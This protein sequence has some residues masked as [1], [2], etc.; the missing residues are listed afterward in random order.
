MARY[1]SDLEDIYF[2]LFNILKV[3]EKNK[4]FGVEEIKSVVMEFDKFVAHEIFSTREEGDQV[5]VK[6][7]GGKVV[8]P[9][10]YIRAKNNYHSNGWFALGM[11][12]EW[13]GMPAPHAVYLACQSLFIGSN[14][15]F[16]MYPGLSK[17][18]LNAIKELGTQEQKERFIPKMMEGAWGGTMCLTEPGAGSDV[19]ATKSTAKPLG[20]GT[21]E[22]KGVKIFISSGESDL[23]E[24][25]IHLVLARTPGAPEGVKG[26]SLFI[27]PRFK[28][29]P[30]GSLGGSNDVD[31]TKVEHKMGI[32]GSATCELTFGNKA[33]CIGV[34]LGKEFQG[35]ANMFLMMN[36]A[37]L[38][39]GLQ[40]ESQATLATLNAI[41]YAK[42]REQFGQAIID[43]PDIRRM[44]LKMRATTRAMKGMILYIGNL[45]DNEHENAEEIAFLTPICKSYCTDF[46]FN[47]CVDA[48]QVHGG[49]G[50][51]VEYGM[52]QFVR[53]SKIA[54]IYEG[55]N[56]IQAIDFVMRKIFRDQG[57]TLLKFVQKIM[58]SISSD[59]PEE[60]AGEVDQIKVSVKNC[61]EI[62]EYF[63]IL[64]KENPNKILEYC[65]DFLNFF[66]NLTLSWILFTHA[67][68]SNKFLKDDPK[69]FYKSKISDFKIF[70]AH[71]L[72]ANKGIYHTIINSKLELS[73]IE[74]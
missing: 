32:H 55:T 61:Q 63:K 39:C 60:L 54:T 22:I 45:F 15:S 33:Q 46:G 21:Y 56:G 43:H 44:L 18:A 30:D 34:L 14:V 25:N 29:N 36:E 31:C 23:Y 2:N 67:K 20:D 59:V 8:A 24:N 57:K 73:K 40:G 13:G 49:Y 72:S 37:R 12:E 51:C 53:D 50:Y 3:Q 74:I 64:S 42:E 70:S 58:A 48:L 19:G 7:E 66:G 35:M 16:S 68:E 6:M 65:S 69:G 17:G 52:E 41:N 4:D 71:N 47:I 10:S 11:E 28:I 38:L 26:L 62:L 27:V 1:F 9:K 5:G